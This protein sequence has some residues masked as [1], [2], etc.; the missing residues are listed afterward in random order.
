MGAGEILKAKNIGCICRRPR[1][2]PSIFFHS[3]SRDSAT[4]F[5]ASSALR[6]STEANSQNT[7][8]HTQYTR[9][10]YCGTHRMSL[11]AI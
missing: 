8:I 7:H 4:L 9:Y 2:G 3:T 1:L 10:V 6:W 11:C 5:W